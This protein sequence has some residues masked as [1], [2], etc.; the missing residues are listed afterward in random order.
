[1]HAPDGI[2]ISIQARRIQIDRWVSPRWICRNPL[3]SSDKR[4]QGLRASHIAA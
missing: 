3:L 2:A 1:M 4:S